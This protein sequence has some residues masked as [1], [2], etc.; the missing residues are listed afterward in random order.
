M[1]PTPPTPALTK[2]TPFA[3]RS[4][5]VA[6]GIALLLSPAIACILFATD[7]D[8]LGMKIQ[9]AFES[10]LLGVSVGLVLLAHGAALLVLR[11]ESR[12]LLEPGE[13]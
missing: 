2:S 7:R 5:S 3:R 11:H 4:M 6:I 13:N 1:P 9:D 12:R 8:T 10:W